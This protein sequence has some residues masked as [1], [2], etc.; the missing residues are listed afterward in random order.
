MVLALHLLLIV[1]VVFGAALLWRWPRSV[2]LHLP[3]ALWGVFVELSGTVCALTPLESRLRQ[4]AGEQGYAGSFVAH[5]LL[6]LIYPDALTRESQVLL[7]AG[8][9]LAN[10]L[11]NALWLARR[12]RRR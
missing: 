12:R 4:T 6:P 3:A 1:Y 8:L 5:Y 11:L 2:W 10:G 7:G 9:V